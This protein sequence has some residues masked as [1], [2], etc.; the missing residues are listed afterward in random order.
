M[1]RR[2]DPND[3]NLYAQE[4]Q[5]ILIWRRRVGVTTDNDLGTILQIQMLSWGLLKTQRKSRMTMFKKLKGLDGALKFRTKQGAL[6]SVQV[7]VGTRTYTE[8]H[9][10]TLQQQSWFYREK[11]EDRQHVVLLSERTCEAAAGQRPDEDGDDESHGAGVVRPTLTVLPPSS[12]ELKKDSVTLVCLASGGFP[13]AWSLAWKV[14]GS[15]SSSGVSRSLALLGS[16]GH[17]SWSSTLSLPADQW[18]KAG[19]VSCEASL[20]GQ[21]PVTQ[22]LDPDRCSE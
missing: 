10:H 14:G 15:S 7:S 19:S 2:N 18:R 3:P 4:V 11:R 12:E 1:R 17:Y 22:T 20:T 6:G 5:S 13:S 8:H 9:H 16:G 21:S